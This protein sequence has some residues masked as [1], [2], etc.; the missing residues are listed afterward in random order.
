MVKRNRS[1]TYLLPLVLSGFEVNKKA[2]L[3][4]YLY[5][6]HEPYMNEKNDGLF[7]ELS[8]K[9]ESKK[10]FQFNPRCKYLAEIDDKSFLIYIECDLKYVGDVS[11]ILQSKYSQISEDAK[12]T[13]F[14]FW[15][16]TA[17]KHIYQVLMKSEKLREKLE[18]ELD[19]VISKDAELGERYDLSKEFFEKDILIKKSI[20]NE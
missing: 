8:Y 16:L 12:R 6:I 14:N 1:T 17:D 5:N 10:T 7:I 19:E 4:S 13:I 15:S 9:E 11:L 20:E 2:I 18:F 3:N